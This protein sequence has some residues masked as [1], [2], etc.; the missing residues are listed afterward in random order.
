MQVYPMGYKFYNIA[1]TSAGTLIVSGS[2]VL[3]NVVIGTPVAN[4]VITVYDGTSTTGTLLS[5][6]TC[7]ATTAPVGT[8]L[9]NAYYKTGLY[10]VSTTGAANVTVTYL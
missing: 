2:G 7:V 10:I 3:Y 9:F 1:T 4:Q 8:I 6:I 5:V